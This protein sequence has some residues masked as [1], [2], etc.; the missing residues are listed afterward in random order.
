MAVWNAFLVAAPRWIIALVLPLVLI[1]LAG[2]RCSIGTRVALTVI[3]YWNAFLILGRPDNYRWGMTYAPL[4]P[5]GLFYSYRALADLVIS[6][7]RGVNR[8]L[9]KI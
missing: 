2:W 9:Q 5:L 1:G 6:S 7:R 3:C 8:P 4:V